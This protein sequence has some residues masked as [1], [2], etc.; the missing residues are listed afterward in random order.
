MREV[1]KKG[2]GSSIDRDGR[3]T[4]IRRIYNRVIPDELEQK[5][6]T[7]PFNFTDDLDV[8]WTGGP[9]WFFRI[10]KFSMPWLRSSVGAEDAVSP[11]MSN[12]CRPSA[13]A[14]CS[15]RCSRSRAAASC[16]RPTDDDIAAIPESERHLYLLQELVEFTPIIETP[17]GPTKAEMRIMMVRDNGAYRAMIPLVRMGRGAMMGVDFNKGQSWVGAA[18][19]L[20]PLV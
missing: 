1:V 17:S 19:G 8:E 20:T 9:D 12:G 16:L 13:S 6:I 15:S 18:A 14:G 7:L 11:A 3:L 5:A 2:R 10:S 4:P